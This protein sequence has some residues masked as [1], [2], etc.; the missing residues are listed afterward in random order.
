MNPREMA[1]S[2]PPPENLS[3][4]TDRVRTVRKQACKKCILRPCAVRD[5]VILNSLLPPED[6]LFFKI[7][8]LLI[9]VGN[10]PRSHC[11]TVT[12]GFNRASQSPRIAK[13]PVKFPDTREFAWRL[14]RSALRRQPTSHSTKECG[15]VIA[16]SARQL[17]LFANW[18]PVSILPN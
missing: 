11:S 10:C 16:I 2:L 7:F 6:S 1:T 14:V 17:R 3:A 13:F 5:S 18:L 4:R 12:S 9:R 8:S 15:S